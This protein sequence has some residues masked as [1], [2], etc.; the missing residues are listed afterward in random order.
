MWA[1]AITSTD[2]ASV[3]STAIDP[4]GN[5]VVA[6]HFRGTLALGETRLMSSSS[7]SDSFVAKLDASGATLWLRH[8]GGRADVRVSAVAVGGDGSIAIGG[9]LTGTL[10]HG[11]LSATGVGSPDGLVGL[12]DRDGK[13]TWL[14]SLAA[15][16]YSAARDVAFTSDG[17]VVATGFFGGH[18]DLLGRP[19]Y[20]GG[21]IDL[22][23]AR[24]RRN[25]EVAWMVRGGGPGA[26]IGRAIT[27]LENGAVAIAGSVM[28]GAS[29]GP[30]VIKVESEAS[31]LLVA[32]V[33]S[34]GTFR[35]ASSIGGTGNDSAAAVVSLNGQ[36]IAGGSA[37]PALVK[38]DRLT[39]ES[40]TVLPDI[41]EVTAIAGA[42]R[43]LAARI[44]GNPTG[45]GAGA[46]LTKGLLHGE[47]ETV[48]LSSTDAVR[49]T[50]LAAESERV[51]AAGTF[52][53]KMTVG[54][55]GLEASSDAGFVATWT[56]PGGR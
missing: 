56:W 6:G 29:F 35:G 9:E 11:G 25:G 51:V 10:L 17:D 49:I 42:D 44:V 19:V 40:A 32:I 45:V 55:T 7:T 33:A 41:V 48:N 53:G 30:H 22:A 38:L 24:F 2:Y 46:A 43:L 13:P 15:S 52:R 27:A 34:D 31:D 36:V 14:T 8:L 3:T 5:V 39:L 21:G 37:A 18:I 16:R 20:S 23:L 4:A 54:R 47:T 12:L 26:D 28:N 50:D 1:I